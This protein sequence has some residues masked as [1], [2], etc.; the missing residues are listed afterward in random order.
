MAATGERS[1]VIWRFSD[2]RAG[3][4]AQSKGLI[5]ALSD[6][7]ECDNY[8]L[9]VPLPLSS[10]GR[11]LFKNSSFANNIPDPDLLVGA[12]H[13]THMPIL[14]AR[15]IRGGKAI[16]LMKP[17]LPCRF[18]DLCLI[19]EHDKIKDGGNLMSTMGPLNLIQSGHHGPADCGLM[20]IGGESKHFIWNEQ[21]L[22]DQIS[23]ILVQSSQR[24]IIA[25][26]PRTPPTTRALLRTLKNSKIQ[27]V[28]YED[29]GNGQQLQQLFQKAGVVWVSE[30]SMS[31]I[32]EALTTGAAAGVLRV[33]GKRNDRIT[34]VARSLATKQMLTLFDDWQPG[35][36]LTPPVKILAE[37]SRCA[38]ALL[39]RFGWTRADQA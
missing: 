23:Q 27:Y 32:Y 8:E 7:I 9:P 12:G 34:K 13:A 35:R 3:H 30:D 38:R 4:D 37:S 14:L 26:S 24:W 15:H 17:S 5:S 21:L 11:G 31:M 1:K 2:G 18:F 36:A 6:L 39:E 25:D 22:L 16:I 33:P 10:Y 20:L 28:P 19:P 29:K